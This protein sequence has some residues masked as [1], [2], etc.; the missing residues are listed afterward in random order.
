MSFL[1]GDCSRARRRQGDG[2]EELDLE[3]GGG[4]EEPII[5]Q[6][7]AFAMPP[8]PAAAP[9]PGVNQSLPHQSSN[10]NNPFTMGA[11]AEPA[12]GGESARL[13]TECGGSGTSWRRM[14]WG[15]GAAV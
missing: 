12:T 2:E 7:Q 6:P 9:A 11:A 4:G 14:D 3:A 1:A 5:D 8:P 13:P 15:G 10:P